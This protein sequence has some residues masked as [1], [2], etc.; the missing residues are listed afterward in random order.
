MPPTTEEH[1]Q[2]YN[3]DYNGTRDNDIAPAPYERLAKDGGFGNGTTSTGGGGS[4]LSSMVEIG[5]K[6]KPIPTWKDQITL[7]SLVV[8]VMLGTIFGMLSIKESL[9]AGT[10]SPVNIYTS[11]VGYSFIKAWLTILETSGIVGQ[12]FTRQENAIIQSCVLGITGVCFSGTPCLNLYVIL[13]QNL[14]ILFSFL[15]FSVLLVREYF[16]I[17]S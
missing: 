14:T 10:L 3:S 7:R 2:Q 13:S 9:A 4:S 17:A 1:E 5:F 16:C 15:L 11:V 8:S 6:G 12:P